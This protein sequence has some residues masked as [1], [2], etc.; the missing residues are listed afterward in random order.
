MRPGPSRTPL[1]RLWSAGDLVHAYLTELLWMIET[2]GT[3]DVDCHVDYILRGW[4]S[5]QEGPFDP[6]LF[7]AEHRGVLRAIARSGRALEVN[8]AGSAWPW[9]VQWWRDGGGRAVTLGSDAH[10]TDRLAVNFYE[11]MDMVEHYGF[12]P[13]R[14]SQ[15]PWTR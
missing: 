10:T 13:G 14:R 6:S 12:Q 5:E 4:P 1:Y 3:F 7:E 15:D 2:G 9:I 8:L 11:A